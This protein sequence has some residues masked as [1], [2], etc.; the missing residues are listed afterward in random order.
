[1]SP[2][3]ALCDTFSDPQ[4]PLRDK[5]RAKHPSRAKRSRTQKSAAIELFCTECMGGSAREAGQCE[6]TD[7]FLWPHAYRKQRKQ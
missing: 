2:K 5:L 3:I 1:M 6:L 7:C 4:Q